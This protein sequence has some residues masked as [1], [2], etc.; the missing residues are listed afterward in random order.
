MA[1]IRTVEDLYY[2]MTQDERYDSL[3]KYYYKWSSE[4]LH[5][6]ERE[7]CVTIDE[8][9]EDLGYELVDKDMSG[10]Y[11][12]IQGYMGCQIREI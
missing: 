3:G 8:K 6:D 2:S 1:K 11:N 10:Y 7:L 4:S 9:L 5:H 12:D